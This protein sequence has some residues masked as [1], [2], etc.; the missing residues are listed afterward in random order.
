MEGFQRIV[1]AFS[2]TNL[3]AGYNRRIGNNQTWIL[4]S[5]EPFGI[6]LTDIPEG[7]GFGG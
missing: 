4:K 1:M 3:R 2:G 5:L 6:M 7:F